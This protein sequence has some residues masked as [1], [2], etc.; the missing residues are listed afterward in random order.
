M[1]HETHTTCRSTQ[2]HRHTDTHTHTHICI[3]MYIYVYIAHVTY[4][5]T[6]TLTHTNNAT[7]RQTD[8]QDRQDRHKHSNTHTHTHTQSTHTVDCTLTAIVC[9]PL[10]IDVSEVGIVALATGRSEQESPL[11]DMQAAHQAE[12]GTLCQ[13][14]AP[15]LLSEAYHWTAI[16][17]GPASRPEEAGTPQAPCVHCSCGTQDASLRR[18]H[19]V[20][21]SRT[22]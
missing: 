20:C 11:S 12:R 21:S 8:R 5:R 1:P 15:A 13:W 17:W 9:V 14:R 3:Y 7:L 16:P 19:F 4:F 18:C 6:D 10:V 2:T 22:G